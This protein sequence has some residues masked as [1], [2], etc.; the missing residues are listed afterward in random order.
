MFE[1][2]NLACVVIVCKSLTEFQ[3]KTTSTYDPTT[4]S[5]FSMLEYIGRG[6]SKPG[7][8]RHSADMEIFLQIPSF[9]RR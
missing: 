4:D 7:L 5:V 3:F 6:S 9:F 2:E 1:H 8:E